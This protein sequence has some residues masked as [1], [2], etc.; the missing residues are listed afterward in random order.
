VLLAGGIADRDDVTRALAAGAEAAVLGTRFLLTEE[1][2]A[3]PG[4]RRRL[5]DAGE[6]VLTELFGMGWPAPHRVVPN[7]ATER[8]LRRDRRGP[9]WVRVLNRVSAPVASRMQADPHSPPAVW[10]RPGVPFF[11]PIAPTDGVPE[12][13]LDAAPLYAGES[14]LRI[15]E[16]TRAGPLTQ[17]LAP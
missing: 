10:Q 15:A 5:L 1:S 11:S 13:W 6:T 14:V 3:H 7:A 8:W 9:G 17:A 12:T 4:Y 16:V 2:A